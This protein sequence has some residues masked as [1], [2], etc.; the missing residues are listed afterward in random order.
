MTITIITTTDH[1]DRARAELEEAWNV[2][3]RNTLQ[4]RHYDMERAYEKSADPT[5]EAVKALARVV[6]LQRLIIDWKARPCSGSHEECGHPI[7]ED[8]ACLTAAL[9]HEDACERHMEGQTRWAVSHE[10]SDCCPA[11]CDGAEHT[12]DSLTVRRVA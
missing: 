4:G 11:C 7:R 10:E 2:V 5:D 3:H 1:A 9:P 8:V 12:A 6:D